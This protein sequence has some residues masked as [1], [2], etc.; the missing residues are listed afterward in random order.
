M[1]K[2]ILVID[3]QLDLAESVGSF[4]ATNGY[5]SH[6]CISTAE[7]QTLLKKEHFDLIISDVVMPEQSG[8]DFFMSIKEDLRKN[9]TSFILMTG[10]LDSIS[11][12][13]AYDLGVDEF[14][15]KPFDLDDLKNVVGLVLRQA[16]PTIDQQKFFR[17]SLTEF[18]Q[19][20]ANRFDIFLQIDSNFMC[21]ARKGQ[22]LSDARLQ[23]YAKK[24]LKYVYLT[25]ADYTKYIDIQFSISTLV[26]SKPLEQVKK[27]KLFTHLTKT[28]STS[29]YCEHMNSEIFKKALTSFEN[30]S[31]IA[32]SHEDIFKILESMSS[33]GHDLADHGAQVSFLS[34]AI[35]IHWKWTHPKILSKIAMAGLLCDVGL[36]VTPELFVRNRTQFDPQHVKQ[37]ENHPYLSYEI[38][39]TIK[40]IPE[41]VLLVAQQHHENEGGFGFPQRLM[42]EK[43][44]PYS[45][46]IHG[47]SEFFDHLDSAGSKSD[48]QKAL[49]QLYSFQRKTISLQVIKTLFIIFGI[50]VPKDMTGILLPYETSRMI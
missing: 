7:A 47:V 42:K 19:S 39:S 6:Y 21:L 36:R 43:L 4:L 25:A 32:F 49:E 17:V 41:E 27:Q 8:I 20:S 29:A 45:R 46:L 22:E 5:Q 24:G 2:N 34:T 14:I 31:Q 9:Q 40:D 48:I 1:K 13:K 15:S 23:N 3:D 30:Y 35:A 16:D 50:D 18:I 26:Q 38:L 10:D 11:M 33:E 12:Q 44:H 37:F 28:I